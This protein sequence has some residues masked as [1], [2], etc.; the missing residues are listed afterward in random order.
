MKKLIIYILGL[1]ALLNLTGFIANVLLKVAGSKV[2]NTGV[3]F[4]FFL[5]SSAVCNYLIKNK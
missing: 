1:L 2:D 5:V 4:M 3:M